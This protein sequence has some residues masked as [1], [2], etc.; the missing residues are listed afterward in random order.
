[1]LIQIMVSFM[2]FHTGFCEREVK[3]GSFEEVASKRT[4]EEKGKW[5]P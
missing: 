1:M 4:G 5:G 2:T 3:E